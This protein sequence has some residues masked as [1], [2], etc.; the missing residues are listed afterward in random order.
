MELTLF[1]PLFWL[2]LVI[3]FG[4]IEI[5]TQG[6][7]TIWFAGAGIVSMIV[8]MLDGPVLLQLILFVLVSFVLLFFTR[9]AMKKYLSSKLVDTNV[10]SLI[11]EIALVKEEIN[12]MENRGTVVIKGMD[13]TARA[14]EDTKTI[15][16]GSKVKVTAIEG[17]KVIVEN[18]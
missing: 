14:K 13:W 16:E 7:T 1:S 9:P 17:V 2:I 15:S 8:S 3:I 18:I 10:D 6:L 11:G 12:N 4:I 5:I